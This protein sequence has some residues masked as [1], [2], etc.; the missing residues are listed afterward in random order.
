[1]NHSFIGQITD[2]LG[3]DLHN[4]CFFVAIGPNRSLKHIFYQEE[5]ELQRK[6]EDYRDKVEKLKSEEAPRTQTDTV[7][8]RL[9]GRHVKIFFPNQQHTLVSCYTKVES[10]ELIIMFCSNVLG[11]PF[12]VI[13]Q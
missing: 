6:I 9:S 12:P 11:V 5:A 7:L 13:K 3:R 10:T 4:Y 2:I 8:M 1:M